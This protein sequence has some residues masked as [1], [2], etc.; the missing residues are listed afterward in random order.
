MEEIYQSKKIK[1]Y[2]IYSN[3][4]WTVEDLCPMIILVEHAK[5]FFVK[6]VEYK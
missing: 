6:D 2:T 5:V 1:I 3:V 4:Q